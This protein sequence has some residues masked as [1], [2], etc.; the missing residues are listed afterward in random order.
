MGRWES[1][2]GLEMQLLT[3]TSILLVGLGEL[4]GRSRYDSNYIEGRYYHSTTT[5]STTISGAVIET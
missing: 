3:L 4:P 5:T 1:S 2:T